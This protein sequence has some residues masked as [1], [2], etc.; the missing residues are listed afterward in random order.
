MDATLD[1]ARSNNLYVMWIKG[2]INTCDCYDHVN[3]VFQS[4]HLNTIIT[5][6]DMFGLFRYLHQKNKETFIVS[7]IRAIGSFFIH[8]EIL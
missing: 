6:L 8:E 2:V 4:M 5:R 3:V 1:Y 7:A